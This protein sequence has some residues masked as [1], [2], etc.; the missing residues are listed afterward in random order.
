VLCIIAR[1][2]FLKVFQFLSLRLLAS[3]HFQAN[4][5]CAQS[6]TA[7]SSTSD[8]VQ[9]KEKKDYCE[10]DQVKSCVN[11]LC[12]FEQVE[13]FVERET[14]EQEWEETKDKRRLEH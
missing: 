14:S 10:Y 13:N 5:L 4:L 6:V 3:D 11:T 7:D 2:N 1:P 12:V 8:S 9:N